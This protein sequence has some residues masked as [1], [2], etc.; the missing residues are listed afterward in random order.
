ME[1]RDDWDAILKEMKE[2]SVNQEFY[3]LQII[4]MMEKLHKIIKIKYIPMKEKLRFPQITKAKA[5]QHK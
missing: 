4:L 3:I 5:I 1:S 2:K